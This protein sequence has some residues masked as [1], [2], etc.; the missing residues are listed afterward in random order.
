MALK[1]ISVGRFSIR[2]QHKA[3]GVLRPYG[4]TDKSKEQY[5]GYHRI[6]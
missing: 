6:A 3:F 4:L 5:N 2:W 1:K